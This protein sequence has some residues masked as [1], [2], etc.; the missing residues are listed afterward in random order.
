M[1]IKEELQAR[2]ATSLDKVTEYI[3]ATGDF[4]IEQAPLVAQEI[5]NLGQ[6]QATIKVTA[7]M[8]ALLLTT[9]FSLYSWWRFHK[10]DSEC[11]IMMGILSGVSAI[12]ALTC[13]CVSIYEAV[14][15][16]IAPRV[17]ILHE[18]QRSM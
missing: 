10:S 8:I 15:P 3:E 1:N 4:V 14:V 12:F 11:W 13:M 17:F 16:F 2:L 5:I 18:I 6:V 9:S 7:I